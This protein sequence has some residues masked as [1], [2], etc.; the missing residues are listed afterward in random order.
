MKPRSDSTAAHWLWGQ[1]Q[2]V[3]FQ[4]KYPLYAYVLA[5]LEVELSPSIPAMAVA[6]R[7]PLLRLSINEA[8]FAQHPHYFEGV[9]LHEIHHVVLGHTSH[10]RFRRAAYPDLMVLATEMSANEYIVAPLPDGI[11]WQQYTA[12]GIGPDQSTLYRY[13]C[14]AQARRDGRLDPAPASCA[15]GCA[16]DAEG[17]ETADS[18]SAATVENILHGLAALDRE[19]SGPLVT[20]DEPGGAT[21]AGQSAAKLVL[22]L[23]AAGP[24][25]RRP[26]NWRAALR[27]FVGSTSPR[28]PTYKRPNRRFPELIGQVPGRGRGRAPAGPPRLLVALDTSQSMHSAD[29]V[30]LAEEIARLAKFATITVVECDECIRRVY[31]Y[32]SRIE[33][34]EGRGGT[35]FRPVFEPQF[36]ARHRPD[37]VVYMTDGEGPW[38]EDPGVRTLWVLT[39][40]PSAFGCPWGERVGLYDAARRG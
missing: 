39:G 16:A 20:E 28:A 21:I 30:L 7:G 22:A 10:A 38:P 24:A 26:V 14:L 33:T 4:D 9:L 27:R 34:V 18:L 12:Y 29:L 19:D 35:S 5:R 3:G 32:V 13:E 11:F 8:Y 17:D 31:A 37:G 23:G 6:A 15:L 25:T 1:L 40:D 36:L 2:A